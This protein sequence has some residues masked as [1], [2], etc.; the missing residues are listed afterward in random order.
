MSKNIDVLQERITKACQKSNRPHSEITLIAV[1]KQKPI[2]AIQAAYDAGLRHFGENRH[3]ELAEKAQALSHLPDIHW[4]YIAPPQSRHIQPIADYAQTFHALDRLKIA[5]RLNNQLNTNHQILNTFTQVNISGET[6]KSGLNL[7][8][9]EN[10]S[11]QHDAL[12]NLINQISGLEKIKPI[13][14]MTMAP[15]GLPADQLTPIFQ[16]TKALADSISH[17]IPNPQL[18]MGMTDDFEL[19]IQEG[20]T[21][22][23][24]GRAI[25]GERNY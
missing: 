19:A 10:S 25:F 1:S 3:T 9:W 14:L 7:T 20:A 21:H 18:S 16:R 8:D 2:S 13:G 24:V 5:T 15:W 17:L 4:H 6:S 23:R 12:I 11:S 22:I